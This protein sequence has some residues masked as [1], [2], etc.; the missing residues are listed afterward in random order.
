MEDYLTLVLPRGH[1]TCSNA[2]GEHSLLLCTLV[3]RSSFCAPSVVPVNI[4]NGAKVVNEPGNQRWSP[5][6]LRE[7]RVPLRPSV[8]AL[9]RMPPFVA[10]SVVFV[11]IDKGASEGNEQA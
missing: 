2:K 1:F 3:R 11:S 7:A 8:Y 10:P 6:D 5:A 9:A 4:G